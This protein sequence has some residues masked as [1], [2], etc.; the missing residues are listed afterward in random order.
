V[1]LEDVLYLLKRNRFSKKTLKI[2]IGGCLVLV[3]GFI[4]LVVIAIVLAFAYRTQIYDGFMGIV[5]FLFGD[6]SDN[7]IRNFLQQL[8]DSFLKDLLKGE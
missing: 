8:A 3:L 2:L 4:L 6:S 7:V 5:N 1:H